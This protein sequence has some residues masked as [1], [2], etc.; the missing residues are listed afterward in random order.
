M[1]RFRQPFQYGPVTDQIKA[2]K[3]LGV[4]LPPRAPSRLKALNRRIQQLRF[5][6]VSFRWMMLAVASLWMLIQR[7]LIP[8]MLADPGTWLLAAFG[9]LQLLVL[10]L[11]Q[12]SSFE[13]TLYLTMVS[14]LLTM[15]VWRMVAMLKPVGVTSNPSLS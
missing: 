15:L 9:S 10:V 12:V 13:S 14:P 4:Q 3:R 1:D 5:T 6:G 11:V 8:Q 2:A 7:R